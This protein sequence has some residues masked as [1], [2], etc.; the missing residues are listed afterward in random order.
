MLS[1]KQFKDRVPKTDE[2]EG[3][4][5]EVPFDESFPAEAD[6]SIRIFVWKLADGN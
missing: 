2:T 4:L 5:I 6:D 3:K 1:F